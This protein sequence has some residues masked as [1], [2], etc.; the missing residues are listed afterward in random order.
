MT[1]PTWPTDLP[2][3]RRDGHGLTRTDSRRRRATDVGAPIYGRRVT[4]AP[5]QIMVTVT[6]TQTQLH[7]LRLFF[8]ET[9]AGGTSYFWLP[10]PSRDGFPLETETGIPLSFDDGTPWTDQAMMLCAWGDGLPEEG[11][12]RGISFDVTFDVWVMP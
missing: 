8:G 10:D 5:L 11:N 9:C 6:V 4:L 7:S 3:P 1:Y 12:W 2:T